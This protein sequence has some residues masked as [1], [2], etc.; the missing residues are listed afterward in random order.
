MGGAINNMINRIYKFIIMC[1]IVISGTVF[2]NIA[3]VAEDSEEQWI[4]IAFDTKKDA[5]EEDRIYVKIHPGETVQ[6]PEVPEEADG[7]SFMG[8]YATYENLHQEL[9]N[10]T[11]IFNE[12]ALVK[13]SYAYV[14]LHRMQSSF[15]EKQIIQLHWR[16]E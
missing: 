7:M 13:P 2:P 12:P 6:F 10:E 8:W 5:S 15:S 1:C 14:P 4:T 9:V 11:T 16:P 3:A